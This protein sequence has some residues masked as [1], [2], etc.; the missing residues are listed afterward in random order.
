LPPFYV[1]LGCTADVAGYLLAGLAVMEVLAG[2]IVSAVINRFPDRRGLLAAS[3]LAILGG[4]GCLIAMPL[5]L[6]AMVLL[7]LGIGSLFPLSL[8]VTLDHA[9][10]PARAGRLTAFV[11]GGGY[12]IASIMPF[13]A[14]W[15]RSRSD[16]FSQGPDGC[17]HRAAP[18]NR[19]TLH[20]G[21]A[22]SL[23]VFGGRRG[24]RIAEFIRCKSP[25]SI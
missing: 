14:G 2:L 23:T 18:R 19:A 1:E 12:L 11:Q 17:Q 21:R 22:H 10:D 15:M 13:A 25:R 24:H 5:T 20:P 6:P 7:G 9:D 8:I 3:L 4:L 16:D